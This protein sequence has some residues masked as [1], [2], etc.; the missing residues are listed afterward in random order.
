VTSPT[1]PKRAS[2][3][4]RLLDPV[5]VF[6][7]AVDLV[8]TD[9]IPTW[10]RVNDG[11]LAAPVLL[12]LVGAVAL[13]LALPDRVV[14][15][16]RWLFPAAVAVL[17][18]VI[19]ATHGVRIGQHRSP[20][21]RGTTL[22]LMLVLSGANIAAGT[23]LVIDLLRSEGLHDAGDLIVT[24][25]AIWLTNVIIF[26]LWY[27]IFDRGGPVARAHA[28]KTYP[29]FLFP[30]MDNVALAKPDWRPVFFDYLYTSFTNAT[31]FSPT[32]VMPLARWAKLMMMLQSAV[33]LLLAI[34]VIAR[35]VNVLK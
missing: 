29:D 28:A 18:V 11:E 22:L 6:G 25:G 10:R 33:A 12:A 9:V 26:A 30:Q 14:D 2:F 17:I 1:D 21:L 32:D 34:L 15:P 7:E 31:A 27:W 13:Q 23:R 8:Q 24:G 19:I 16:V 20:V 3:W 4:K 5:G 35:A